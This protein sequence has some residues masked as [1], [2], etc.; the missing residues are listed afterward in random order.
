MGAV[1]ASPSSKAM[2]VR[3]ARRAC[4]K[5]ATAGAQGEC[6]APPIV[7]LSRRRGEPEDPPADGGGTGL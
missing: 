3:A 7:K 4:G 6:G 5:V 2:G 1:A